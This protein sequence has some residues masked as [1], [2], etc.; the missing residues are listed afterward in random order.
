MWKDGS[1][2]LA[3]VLI[4]HELFSEGRGDEIT[5]K[6]KEI[7]IYFDCLLLLIAEAENPRELCIFQSFYSGVPK[8]PQNRACSPRQTGVSSCGGLR[9]LLVVQP[10]YFHFTFFILTPAVLFQFLKTDFLPRGSSAYLE[11]RGTL[12]M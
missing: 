6:H 8:L 11:S 10:L 2:A 7:K 9:T 5:D 4:T 3:S 1:Q 12:R